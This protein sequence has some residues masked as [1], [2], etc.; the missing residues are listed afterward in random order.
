MNELNER[1]R[2]INGI[3][4]LPLFRSQ[5]NKTHPSSLACTQPTEADRSSPN[6][7]YTIQN[8]S[9]SN[10]ILPAREPMTEIQQ[11][12]TSV[13]DNVEKVIV[14]KRPAIEM[15]MVAM[16]CEGHVL[17]ED[18]PGVGKTML[19]RSA[20]RQPERALQPPAVHP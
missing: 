15:L 9:H 8:P 12:V 18:V 6:L 10:L 5:L 17:L 16:L 1:R 7:W 19:A 4:K 13:I 14:G 11:F 3:L 2:R 20:G